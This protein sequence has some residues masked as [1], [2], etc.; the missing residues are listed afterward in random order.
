MFYFIF[1]NYVF[2]QV[3]GR[4]RSPGFA[5]KDEMH[6]TNAFI[7]ESYRLVSFAY[8]SVPH[9]ASA[10]ITIGDYIIPKGAGIFPSLINV[11]YDPNHFPDPHSFKPERFLDEEGKYKHDDRV[12]PFGVGK[13]YCLGQTLAEKEVFLF[14]VGMLQKFDITPAAMEKLPSYHIED[15]PP[16]NFLRTCPKYKMI[17]NLRS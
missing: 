7:Q 1:G 13:R 11:M 10:D 9:Y 15:H 6:Y 12:I 17:F 14:L 16:I 4:N 8:F 3:I 5:D 2:K